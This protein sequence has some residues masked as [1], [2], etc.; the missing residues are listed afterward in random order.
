MEESAMSPGNNSVVASVGA[1]PQPWAEMM[2]AA[3]AAVVPQSP[4]RGVLSEE[5]T[6]EK[7]LPGFLMKFMRELDRPC[8]EDEL[9]RGASMVFT[10]L[11][12]PDGTR[13]RGEVLRSVKGALSAVVGLF[14]KDN[15]KNLW[16]LNESAARSYEVQVQEKIARRIASKRR[17]N[18]RR[19]ERTAAERSAYIAEQ[20]GVDGTPSGANPKRSPVSR[21]DDGRA[22]D[23]RHMQVFNATACAA[24]ALRITAGVQDAERATKRRKRM[25][26]RSCTGSGMG[27]VS[28]DGE[29]TR[30]YYTDERV[31][32][33]TD[34]F[35][36]FSFHLKKQA[37]WQECFYSP[38]R[39]CRGH[40]NEREVW[41][42]I[43]HERFIGVL[44]TYMF[45]KPLLTVRPSHEQYQSD[46]G[47]QGPF[48]GVHETYEA[49]WSAEQRIQGLSIGISS[50]QAF[51]KPPEV[52]IGTSNI[53]MGN[54]TSVGGTLVPLS[55]SELAAAAAAAAV[56]SSTLPMGVDVTG[57]DLSGLQLIPGMTSDINNEDFQAFVNRQAVGV[58]SNNDRN[59][60][61][62]LGG[63]SLGGPSLGGPSLGG[64]SL[65]GGPRGP[66][67]FLTGWMAAA[68]DGLVPGGPPGGPTDPTMVNNLLLGRGP[69]GNFSP[70]IAND[71]PIMS[72]DRSNTSKE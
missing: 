28:T 39:N 26:A 68:N 16:T 55:H 69:M 48:R 8:T 67:S 2:A 21:C 41:T 35:E 57:L 5:I 6:V 17:Q 47:C 62:S 34:M 46:G 30:L 14:H 61:A 50:I 29:L 43:G 54:P 19:S 25:D 15:E 51:L 36:Q 18:A 72:T 64:A 12:K 4:I 44:Q 32:R 7:T 40:E 11:R 20:S 56:S 71:F 22:A 70:H 66:L 59:V 10:S 33:L 3:A 23:E 1:S 58:D 52:P 65:G 45:L 63:P 42:K 38:F 60:L 37:N 53:P 24:S 13:Y 27:D 49:L 9:V 31:K